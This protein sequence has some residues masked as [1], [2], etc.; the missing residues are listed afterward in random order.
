MI[1]A[2]R[3]RSSG[4]KITSIQLLENIETTESAS[5]LYS[6]FC[7]CMMHTSPNKSAVSFKRYTEKCTSCHGN[8][9]ADY[10]Y[11][12]GVG[13]PCGLAILC[14]YSHSTSG[15]CGLSTVQSKKVAR[16]PAV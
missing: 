14:H 4:E 10:Y 6:V 13:T 2:I 7:H 9:E 5:K 8:K 15:S 3:V 11:L 12:N 16:E 1:P